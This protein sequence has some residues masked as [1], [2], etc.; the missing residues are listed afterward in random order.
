MRLK[1]VLVVVCSASLFSNS[2]IAQDQ[3]QLQLYVIRGE[4][5]QNNVKKGRATKAV[6]E[7]RDRNNKPVAGAAVLF[8]LPDSG[9]G[10]SF[11]GGAQSATVTT[12]SAGQASVT[13]TPNHVNG[14]FNIKV[15]VKESN[16]NASIH[17]K[18]DS[19]SSAGLS[20]PA[21]I[22]LAVGAGA[23]IGVGVGLANSG[24]GGST[25]ATT[26]VLTPGGVSIT[27]PK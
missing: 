21:L 11:V 5:A 19:A 10:G 12:D 6:V 20:T 22:W 1:S 15:S 16:A 23:A 9:P 27:P 25:R 3:P 2:V 13:Y 17:Q 18:N 14:D 24:G 26:V 4:N 7:V 8:L